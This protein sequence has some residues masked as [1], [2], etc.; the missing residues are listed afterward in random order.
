MVQR[1]NIATNQRSTMLLDPSPVANA[2]DIFVRNIGMKLFAGAKN[3]FGSERTKNPMVLYTVS[4]LLFRVSFSRIYPLLIS[5]HSNSA[6]SWA[7]PSASSF[8]YSAP[9]KEEEKDAAVAVEPASSGIS[10]LFAIPIGVALAVPILEFQW[11]DPDAETLLA[12]TFLGFCVV[13]YTQ[14]GDMIGNLFKDEAKD[15]LKAQNEAEEEVIAKL[16]QSVDYMKLTENIVQDYQA[17]Y[18]LT[19]TSY[20]KLSA[21]G[22]IKPQHELK[23][24]MEKMLTMIKAEE[25][26]QYEKAKAAMMVD[27]TA[28]VTAEFASNKDLKKAALNSAIAKL[29]GK[30]K[31]ATSEP[32]RDE[33]VKYFQQTAANA[34]A[35]DDGSEE[36]AARDTMIAKLNSAADNDGMYFDFDPVKGSPRWVN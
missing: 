22:K 12:S 1:K 10:P 11:F 9:R 23:A 27:A 3:C 26:N 19:E 35:K 18:D 17:V 15:I 2:I 14:G 16:Q 13:A 7:A 20:A 34:K 31:A 36:K 5:F 24:Q 28:A 29:T 25:S 30:G 21:S 8:H 4:N 32:V 6:R 33:F